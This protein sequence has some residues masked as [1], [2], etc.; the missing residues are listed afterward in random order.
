MKDPREFG[1]ELAHQSG[2][3]SKEEAWRFAKE[4]LGASRSREIKGWKVTAAD[5]HAFMAGWSSVRKR[6]RNPVSSVQGRD[7]IQ[8]SYETGDP[9]IRRRTA[10]LK[11]LGYRA[12]SFPMGNQVTQWGNVKL[13]MVDIRAGSSGDNYLTNVP[14]AKNPHRGKT[15]R[16]KTR[17]A[18]LTYA[19]EHGAK[20]FSIKKL[21]RGR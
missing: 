14:S 19:R 3:N 8:E 9:A 11:K 4:Q 7:W 5:K 1:Q 12:K 2:W 17:A 15:L 16:F 6:R 10:E 18:A 20:R 21:K 13:T